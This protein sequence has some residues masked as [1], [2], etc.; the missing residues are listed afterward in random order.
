MFDFVFDGGMW[1]RILLYVAV[2][3]G[4]QLVVRDYIGRVVEKAVRSNKYKS[5]SEERQ[6]EKTLTGLFRTALTVAIWLIGVILI[7]NEFNVNLAA[8]ATGAGL[9]GI[10]IGFGAQ[11][12][13]KDFL[14][15]IFIILENQYR[16]GDVVTIAGHSGLVESV[17][18]RMTKLRDLDG[19]VYYVPNGEI[20]TVQNMTM[21]YSGVVIDVGI[22]YD[23]DVRKAEKIINEVGQEMAED[24]E[25]KD[26][27]IEP[28]AFLR[29]NSFGDS[30]V[31][32]KAVGKTATLE[33]WNVAGEYRTRLKQAF[34]KQGIEI[35]FPQ[36]VIHNA[37]K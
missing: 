32:L 23:A 6:R 17:S 21:E 28:I 10:V 3:A 34:D 11:S 36:R 27:I 4:I 20:N 19:S 9:I 5:K 31:N 1:F 26:R 16:V 12:T 13:V 2:L 14:S 7:L 29:L 33:Q 37:K 25:W 22:S 8:L 35:P 18:I 15:G 24:E 30:S